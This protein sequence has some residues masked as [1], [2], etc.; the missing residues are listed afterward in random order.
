MSSRVSRRAL[1]GSAVALAVSAEPLAGLAHAAARTPKVW[2]S[3]ST[4]AC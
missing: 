3:A 2:S 4:A 1:L